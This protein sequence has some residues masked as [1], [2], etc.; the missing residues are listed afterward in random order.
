MLQAILTGQAKS[1]ALLGLALG[2]AYSGASSLFPLAIAR[3][4]P[5][6]FA[7]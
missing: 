4:I 3:A 6:H 7:P 1:I 2:L 5:R